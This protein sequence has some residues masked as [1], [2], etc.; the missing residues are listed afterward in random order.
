MLTTKKV[1]KHNFYILGIPYCKAQ[2]LLYYKK[3]FSYCTGVYGWSCDNY[4]IETDKHNEV[5]IST[6]Y[7]YIN[8]KNMLKDNYILDRHEETARGIVLNHDLTHEQKS[9]LLNKLLNDMINKFIDLYNEVN[10]V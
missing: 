2:H 10:Y 9:V 1:I 5:I 4:Y 7:Q 8:S 3:A 6:G